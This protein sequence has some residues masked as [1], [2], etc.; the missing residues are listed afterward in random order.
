DLTISADANQ[1]ERVVGNLVANAIKF[2][3]SEGS[4]AVA[5]EDFPD[6]VQ[7]TVTDTGPGIPPDYKDRIFDKFQQVKGQR[8][9]G[10]G[11]GLTICKYFVELHGGKIWVE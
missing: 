2:T 3:P 1:I 11:L 8:A 4:V 5:L 10:T 7:V 6:H 9:G